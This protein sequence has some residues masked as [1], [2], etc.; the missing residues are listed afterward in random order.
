M[1][2]IL[3]FAGTIEGRKIASFLARK[4]VEVCACVA[5]EYGETVIEEDANLLPTLMVSCGRLDEAQMEE[6][7]TRLEGDFIID[8]THPYAVI[9]SEN[10]KKACEKTGKTYK[11]LLRSSDME[12]VSTDD[13]TIV[14]SVEEAVEVLQ[15]TTGN[16]LLTTGSKELKKYTKLT[17]FEKRLYP[18]FLPGAQAVE[19]CLEM[20]YQL[21]NLIC[22]QGPFSEELN[23]ALLKQIKAS[24][25]VTKES[26]KA[27]GFEEK[28]CAAKKA[29][30]KLIVIGRPTKEE[31]L[32]LE[33]MKSFL[34][35]QLHL[36][37][38]KRKV[39][40]IGIGM[41]AKDNMTV[42]AVKA[43]KEADVILGA[44]RML[45]VCASLG[46]PTY[47]GYKYEL[48]KEYLDTHT[49]Y[50][51]AVL[52]M[53]GDIGFYSG[54]KKMIEYLEKDYEVITL[55]G[56][57]S[58]VY[59]CTKLHTSWDDVKLMSL[60][61]KSGNLV[62]A[63][64][65]NK[66]VFSLIGGKDAVGVLASELCEYGL[67]DVVIH[68][69]KDLSYPEETILQGTAS[70][71]SG[72]PIGGLCVIL[73][74]NLQAGQRPLTHG[75]EDSEFIRAKVPMTKAEIRSISLS[76]L[77]LYKDSI[78]YDVGAGT[79][80]VSI[81]AALQAED[82]FVYAIEKN[83][84]ACALIEENKRKF[85]TANIQVIS[86]LAPEALEGLPTPTHAF[87]GGSS[88]NM[89][90]ILEVLMEKNPKIRVVINTIALESISETL[91]C[92]KELPVKDVDIVSVNIA[93]SRTLGRY[94]MMTGL[95]PIYIVSF[96]ADK[97][98]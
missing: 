10:I 45:E 63:V 7:M 6:M 43:C 65:N 52:L 16:V 82:G 49:E 38:D 66:K 41:G 84:E 31:G 36:E 93:K 11:R 79:G 56:I 81:E 55:S 80:S 12:K 86:G 54:A 5:T 30:V 9:V 22:M 2:K 26:G 75:I 29:G 33:E 28:L 44:S 23:V 88:G 37:A 1:Y 17:D 13:C 8:A 92:I 96:T 89:K 18:R 3:V 59:F 46:K 72:Q 39:T 35:E 98:S 53:S 90:E 61:G 27:G 60:H 70:E 57:S 94:H 71:L 50:K 40:I 78:L 69:G 32:S 24:Y 74:E 73:V 48:L 87:I 47:A 14:G 95:N 68:V 51:N 76:K 97:E 42:E 58:V 83:E 25:M 67:G 21:K 62:A 15:T 91:A 4:G 85:H 77:N 20:G 19:D 64:A 34:T